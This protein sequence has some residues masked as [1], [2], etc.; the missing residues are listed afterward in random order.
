MPSSKSACNYQKSSNLKLHEP[1]PQTVTGVTEVRRR[2]FQKR[3]C[4]LAPRM[5]Q[6]WRSSRE[7]RTSPVL[8]LHSQKMFAMGQTYG[9][10]ERDETNSSRSGNGGIK[11]WANR[12][13]QKG[14]I[15]RG[16]C[17][18]GGGGHERAALRIR[19]LLD[20]IISFGAD[21]RSFAPKLASQLRVKS[22]LTYSYLASTSFL[23][24][25]LDDAYSENRL[26]KLGVIAVHA[27]AL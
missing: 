6:Y 7:T 25:S 1:L 9:S 23:C 15:S 18:T 2:G 11:W 10:G 21:S 17:W 12:R 22:G 13:G 24:P 8:L 5:R 14:V 20:R 3:V 4:R 27:N 16:W 26:A 19:D